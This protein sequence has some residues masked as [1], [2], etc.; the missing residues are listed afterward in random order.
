MDEREYLTIKHIDKILDEFEIYIT[1]QPYTEDDNRYE[2]PAYCRR[3]RKYGFTYEL[4]KDVVIEIFNKQ[5]PG[6]I[7]MSEYIGDICRQ[8]GL[9]FA[10]KTKFNRLI[11]DGVLYRPEDKPN[12]YCLCPDAN[13]KVSV[14]KGMKSFD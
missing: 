3:R 13:S 9:H 6:T 4:L 11:E 1:G 5:P 10:W 8:Y 2:L 12:G 14:Y 7:L